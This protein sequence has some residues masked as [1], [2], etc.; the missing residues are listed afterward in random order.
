[1][2]EVGDALQTWVLSELPHDWR[3]IEGT[4][5]A[6]SNSVAA[7]QLADHRLA[8]LDYEGSVSGD[9]GTVTRLDAGTYESRRRAPDRLLVDAAGETIHGEIELQR[10]AGDASQWQLSFRPHSAPAA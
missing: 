4:A 2:L 5:I 7:V 1:M 10:T 6:A 9:R 3:D 8:Y